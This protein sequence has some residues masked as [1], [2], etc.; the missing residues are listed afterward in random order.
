M[1]QMLTLSEAAKRMGRSRNTIRKWI[2]KGDLPVKKI[3]G[4]FLVSM[5]N[6]DKLMT[7]YVPKGKEETDE[8]TETDKEPQA[9]GRSDKADIGGASEDW[10]DIEAEVT[11]GFEQG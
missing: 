9:E 1:N 2:D 7:D 5:D 10:P 11:R 6:L 8:R 3:M 4:Q